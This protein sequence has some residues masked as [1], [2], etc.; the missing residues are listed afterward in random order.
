MDWA[1]V[2]VMEL[3]VR[4]S[5]CCCCACVVLSGGFDSFLYGVQ[6]PPSFAMYCLLATEAV[7]CC[8]AVLAGMLCA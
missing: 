8:A 4:V 7:G 2:Y 6:M 5:C 3:G 1:A